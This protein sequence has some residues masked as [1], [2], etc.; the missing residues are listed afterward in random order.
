MRT[1]LEG[2][3]LLGFLAALMLGISAPQHPVN[4]L[5]ILLLALVWQARNVRFA[6]A[7]A[8]LLGLLISPK[9]APGLNSDLYIDEAVSIASVPRIYPDMISFEATARHRRLVVYVRGRPEVSFGARVRIKGVAKPLRLSL[10]KYQ[11]IRGIQGTLFTNG[12]SIVEPSPII[13]AAADRWRRSFDAFAHANLP[14]KIADVASALCFNLD[15]L[16][17]DSFEEQLM[18]TGTIHIVSVSGLHVVV[19]TF[20]LLW[21]LSRVPIPRW[22][23]LVIAALALSFYA[24]ATGLSPPTV[25]AVLMALVALVAYMMKRESDW[26]SALACSA[27]LYLFW[28][29]HSIYDI[30]FQLSFLTVA[31]FCMYL[32]PS[33]DVAENPIQHWLNLAKE[34]GAASLVASIASAPLVAFHFGRVSIVGVVANLLIAA[35]VPFIIVVSFVAHFVSFAIPGLGGAM[36][37]WL[38]E[39]WIGYLYAVLDFMAAPSWA[40]L[41]VPEFNGYWLVPLYIAG[42]FV[43]RVHV[44]RA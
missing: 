27:I 34:T 42:M 7:G 16:L 4:L 32:V 40:S 3:P 38:V 23:Q 29:P 12:F 30:G 14:V 1:E 9:P 44:R 35:V 19:L 39:P 13:S 22:L 11:A 36:L 37:R 17:D 8:L 41:P 43:W 15:R 5:G 24:L 20:S 10:A 25:R 31:A 2:R 26:L 33:R 18:A 28:K 6:M 21:T